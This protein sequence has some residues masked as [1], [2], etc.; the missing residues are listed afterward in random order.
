[1]IDPYPRMSGL[2]LSNQWSKACYSYGMAVC[3]LE[4]GGTGN[5][6][7]ATKLMEQ[8]P[9]LRQKIAGKSI[10]LEVIILPSSSCLANVMFYQKFVAR[11]ARK[12]QT[13]GRLAL[14][15]LELGYL[16][17]AIAH[18]P[19]IV[20]T[21]KMLPEVEKLLAKLK[22]HESDP[23]K[24]EKGQGY[25]DDL[26]LAKFLEGVCCRYVAYP[27]SIF[28]TSSL[29]ELKLRQDPDAIVDENDDC[30]ISKTE[31]TSRAKSAFEAVF[32]NGPKIELDHHLVYH[33]RKPC[34]RSHKLA[35]DL[36][37]QIRLR[38]WSFT[39]ERGR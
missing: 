2:T 25:A 23:K 24:Y 19:R 7:E 6:K 39:L 20:V 1:M 12:Y 22:E 32:L 11:K 37:V 38:T 15:V 9:S 4:I 21:T 29:S 18:A 30:G 28:T 5:I 33:A 10:P 13:Q 26:C 34:V 27:V 8:V 3:L 17:L 14:P 16:F 31:A 35:T 36:F